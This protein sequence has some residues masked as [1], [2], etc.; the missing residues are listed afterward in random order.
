MYQFR[1][2]APPRELYAPLL[3][4][5]S[6]RDDGRTEWYVYVHR[7]RHISRNDCATILAEL[8]PANVPATMAIATRITKILIGAY[9]KTDLTDPVTFV[10]IIAAM[11]SD[12]PAEVALKPADDLTRIC[13]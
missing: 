10:R 9:R 4:V 13:R 2:P 8:E 11:F 3:H 7:D 6:W 1:L 12:Y 5:R